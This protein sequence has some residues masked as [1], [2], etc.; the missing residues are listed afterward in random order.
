MPILNNSGG[1]FSVGKIIYTGCAF[2]GN[3][4]VKFTG[5]ANQF[6]VWHMPTQIHLQG[7]FNVLTNGHTTSNIKLLQGIDHKILVRG[8][9]FKHSVKLSECAKEI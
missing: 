9:F 2:L 3:G 7:T 8:L 6:T 1:H 4:Q 5:W